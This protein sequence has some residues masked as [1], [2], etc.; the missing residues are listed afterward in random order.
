MKKSA[1]VTGANNPIGIGASIAEVL[2][3]NGYN[4]FLPY[5]RTKTEDYGISIEDAEKSKNNG[6][7][8]YHYQRTKDTSE[9][10]QSLSKY[11]VKIGT[12]E[13]D[14]EDIK[15]IPMLFKKAEEEIGPI[16]VLINNASHFSMNDSL[17][18]IDSAS[19]QKSFNV[20]SEAT[21]AMTKVFYDRYKENGLKSGRIVN[22][23]TDS[24]QC[25][26]GQLCYG[27]SKA[28]IEAFTRSS[29]YELGPFGVTVNAIA[30]GPV[31]S[32]YISEDDEKN[33]AKRIPMQRIGKPIDIANAVEFLVSSKA[34]WITGQ[35]I[36]VSGGHGV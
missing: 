4:L 31:Q 7:A 29:S 15:S 9:V 10:I 13:L 26:V 18:S 8:H 36:K 20:N 2:A 11:N 33:I 12:T 23:S 17:E 21:I 24:A 27:S 28:A 14:L 22:L 19:V 25:F 5:F 1:I 35:V 6:E 3:Q 34:E 16:S 30:P 32:G